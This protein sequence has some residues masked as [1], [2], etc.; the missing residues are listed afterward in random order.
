VVAALG[1]SVLVGLLSGVLLARRATRLDTVD[2][3]R[4]E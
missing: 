3:L 4:A 2:A 1:M